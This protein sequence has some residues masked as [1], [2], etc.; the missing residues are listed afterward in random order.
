MGELSLGAARDTARMKG[1]CAGLLL[2]LCLSR[3]G[4]ASIGDERVFPL[5]DVV[6][7]PN[8]VC[9]DSN[10]NLNGTCYTS[11]TCTARGG[12]A[13]SSCA[14]GFGVCCVIQLTASGT[15]SSDNN[16]YLIQAATTGSDTDDTLIDYSIT[17]A[18]TDICRIKFDFVALTL[19]NPSVQTVVAVNSAFNTGDS[20]GKCNTDTLMISGGSPQAPTICGSNTGQHMILDASANGHVLSVKLGSTDT[21]TSRSWTIIVSQYLCDERG[22]SLAGPSGCLQYFT[23]T[24]GRVSSFGFPET[25]ATAIGDDVTHLA[26]QE[27]TICFRREVN[28][29]VMC[30]IPY[31]NVA[32]ATTAQA[33]FGLSISSDASNP[34]AGIDTQCSTDYLSI[35]NGNSL[36]IANIATPAVGNSRFCGRYFT[37]DTSAAIGSSVC[38][39]N[40]PFQLGV[41]FDGT[42]TV[43]AM[44]T[45]AANT[46]ELTTFPGGIIGF[47]LDFAQSASNC[48]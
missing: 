35:P 13:G 46:D 11:S 45:A 24:T 16:T 8:D 9:V 32:G 3:A 36:T 23:G 28:Q 39:R 31:I 21:A 18:S 6:Q 41:V 33:S 15:S 17:R 14:N 42:E 2:A 44:A 26:N 20:I 22:E 4:A 43:A 38:T 34:R 10:L 27:Y 37:T 47:A 1:L 48:A 19:A 29:C 7:F 30:F 25:T 5:F 12:T 40:T